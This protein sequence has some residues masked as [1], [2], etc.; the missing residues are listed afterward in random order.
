M[1]KDITHKLTPGVDFWATVEAE[2]RELV[3]T[4][5]ESGVCADIVY[6][7][8]HGVSI[9][10]SP[11]FSGERLTGPF[12]GLNISN[13]CAILIWDDS[14][15]A[16]KIIVASSLGVDDTVNTGN[17]NRKYWIILIKPEQL[18]SFLVV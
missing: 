13:V 6:A 2:I 18:C 7:G 4:P 17:N 15:I 10:S 14:Y 8:F 11:S 3:N 16:G 1:K 12:D 9:P 5:S